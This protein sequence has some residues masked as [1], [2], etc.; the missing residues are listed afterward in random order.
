[1]A[2]NRAALGGA[3]A[4][5]L[6]LASAM[7]PQ[8]KPKPPDSTAAEEPPSISVDVALVNVLCSVHNKQGGLIGNLAK[9]DFTI[10]EDGKPQAIKY[11]TRET[12]LPLTMGLLIDVSASQKNLLDIEKRAARQFFAQVLRKKDEAF[13][14]SFGEDSDLLQDYTNSPHLLDG[15]LEKLQVSSGVSGLQPGPVPTISQP[16]GTVL[17][18]AVYA[19]AREKLHGEVGRKA[20]ILITDGIDQGS[21]VSIDVAIESAQKADAV[22]YSIDYADPSAYGG[23][24]FGSV[25]DF[26]L[27]RMSKE[28]GGRVFKV[29][30]KHTLEDVFKEIQEEMRSQY[31]IAYS[32]TN[33][34]KNGGFRKLDVKVS[35]KNLKVQVR[36]GYY[37]T[38]AETS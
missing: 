25:S 13:L 31:A 36:K 35:D 10:L 15:A 34:V 29:D 20:L 26:A 21:R 11:F 18:D 23:F 8:D 3:A 1:M 2:L 22:V 16:R 12:D 28:T 32:S 9:D 4:Y 30:R 17:Y 14:V 27:Q 19:A 6:V 38:I 33:P 24:G 37:A 7:A 5:V